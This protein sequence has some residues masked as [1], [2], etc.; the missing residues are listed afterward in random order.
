MGDYELFHHGVKGM[1]WGVRR[2]PEQLGHKPSS[3]KNRF[4]KFVK[5]KKQALEKRKKMRE[6]AELKK[7][8][9]KQ[10]EDAET[11]KKSR[12][13]KKQQVLKSRSAKEL[14][15]NAHLFST[16]ELQSAY[17]RLVLEKNI[18]DLAPKEV[19]KGEQF[20]D[21]ASKWLKKA[22]TLMTNAREVYD[23]ANRVKSMF[24]S[25]D[26][27]KSKDTNVNTVTDGTSRKKKK[28]REVKEDDGWVTGK[29]STPPKPSPT[30]KP[31]RDPIIV[32]DYVDTGRGSISSLVSALPAS[33]TRVASL[34]PA[35]TR[36]LPSSVSS[37]LALPAPRDDD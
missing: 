10:A 26:N 11:I 17:G 8:Q 20:V 6:E 31:K 25:G 34:P 36:Q 14:Y 7:K 37:Y 24:G 29:V 28:E 21:N 18:K 19:N 3:A 1:K 5:G 16:P 2:T 33:S 12:E 15:D 27:N 13:A 9:Q 23:A 32:D 30:P 35:S 22:S 4:A